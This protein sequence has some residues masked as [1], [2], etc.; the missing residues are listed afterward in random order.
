MMLWSV[1]VAVM[2]LRDSKEMTVLFL[3]PKIQQKPMS[4]RLMEEKD[5]I[6]FTCKRISQIIPPQI[7]TPVDVISKYGYLAREQLPI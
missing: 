5:S 3:F 7:A 1:V 2:S 4:L 6:V